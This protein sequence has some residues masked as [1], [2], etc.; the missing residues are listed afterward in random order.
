VGFADRPSGKVA[1]GARRST[2][3]GGKAPDQSQPARGRVS[4]PLEVTVEI[5]AIEIV[6]HAPKR[7][8]GARAVPVSLGEYLRSRSGR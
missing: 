6:E 5:G 3:R 8:A 1:T 7:T 2:R 4:P